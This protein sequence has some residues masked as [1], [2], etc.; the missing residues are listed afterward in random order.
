MRK[1]A[2]ELAVSRQ[3]VSNWIR[4]LPD[5][6]APP[7]AMPVRTEQLPKARI[8]IADVARHAGVSTS[9]VSNYLNDKGRMSPETRWRVED[10]MKALY[11]TPNALVRAIRR[12]RTHTLGFVSYGIDELVENVELSVVAP[13]LG[14]INRAAD[15]AKYDVLLYT[16]WPHR[17]RSHT[18]LD[19]LNGQIDGLLWMSPQQHYSQLRFAAAGGL[20]IVALLTRRVPHGVGYVVADNVEGIRAV[21]RHL[22]A[23]GHTRIAFLG[24]KLTSDFID[25]MAGY[26]EGLAA[27]GIAYGPELEST[28]VPAQQWSLEG[29]APIVSRWLQ[30]PNGPTAIVAVDD[31]LAANTIKLVRDRGLRVPEDVAVTGFN[32]VPASETLFGGI[33]TVDQPLRE[34][35]RIAVERLVALIDGAPLSECRV[36]VPTSLVIRSSA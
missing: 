17:A 15:Q 36:T 8:T 2:L 21:M 27:A 12:G 29:V 32:N 24:S 9:T 31:I 5:P 7:A 26:R 23:R 3:T 25:R 11:F 16:G 10:A 22:V 28:D 18:G 13:V 19:F 33:T 6:S 14:A 30:M 4:D 1:I 35:A 34:I 20:S